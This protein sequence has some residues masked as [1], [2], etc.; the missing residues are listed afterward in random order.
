MPSIFKVVVGQE[1]GG[2]QCTAVFHYR[3]VSTIPGQAAELVT[4]FTDTIVPAYAAVQN[5]DVLN[6]YCSVVNLTDP[7]DYDGTTYDG[8]GSV[9]TSGSGL[10]AFVA[11][12]VPF[13]LAPSVIKNGYKR[14]VGVDESYCENKSLNVA[15]KAALSSLCNVL[16]AVVTGTLDSYTP[17][18]A[19]YT[20]NQPITTYVAAEIV[21]HKAFGVT[22]QNSRK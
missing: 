10:P 2:Q 8:H 7:T 15:G 4:A 14:I 21:G 11:Y 16:E 6:K 19:R 5:I 22:T 9:G 3:A 12:K 17:I 18:V 20:G 13:K 1:Y